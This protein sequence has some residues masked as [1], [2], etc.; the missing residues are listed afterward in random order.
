MTWKKAFTQTVSR[1]GN[2]L[3]FWTERL[4]TTEQRTFSSFSKGEHRDGI[5]LE[6]HWRLRVALTYKENDTVNPYW[7]GTEFDIAW[8]RNN[9]LLLDEVVLTNEPP[10]IE[11]SPNVLALEL[12][13]K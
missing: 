5:A 12:I 10:I 9:I 2:C 8:G 3:D 6:S 1:G 13:L 11:G 4:I 7:D